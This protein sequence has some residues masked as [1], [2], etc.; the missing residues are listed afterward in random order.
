MNNRFDLSNVR[1]NDDL[2]ALFEELYEQ[3]VTIAEIKTYERWLVTKNERLVPYRPVYYKDG[4]FFSMPF[5]ITGA[6]MF[7]IEVKGRVFVAGFISNVRATPREDF[8]SLR[9]RI[10]DKFRIYPSNKIFS[11]M[12]L[13]T[14]E[15]EVMLFE[16]PYLND[17]DGAR[18]PLFDDAIWV[19]L[20]GKGN[21]YGTRGF[22]PGEEANKDGMFPVE[23]VEQT[24]PSSIGAVHLIL[25]PWGDM[26][27]R[28][29][30]DDGILTPET[31]EMYNQIIVY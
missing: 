15:E 7:G 30:L 10:S 19:K 6:P 1:P 11:A 13:P 22:H 25:V 28:G 21:R 9:Y 17:L 3:R 8:I 23:V 29:E 5:E 4:K 20:G 26:L 27:V 14:V 18:F 24:P 31:L 16:Q 12:R 2:K